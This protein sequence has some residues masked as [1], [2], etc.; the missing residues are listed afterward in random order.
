MLVHRVISEVQSVTVFRV[1]CISVFHYKKALLLFNFISINNTYRFSNQ[2]H[3][4]L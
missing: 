4:T 3:H 2:I 1:K